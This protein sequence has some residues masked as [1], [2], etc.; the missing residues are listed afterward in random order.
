[1]SLIIDWVTKIIL[2]L[3]IAAIV[4][5][6]LP[7]DNMKKYAKL[8][9]G[10]ILILIMM[11][12]LFDLFQADIEQTVRASI[13]KLENVQ[14]KD[15]SIEKE[16]ELQKI[17]IQNGQHAYILEQMAVQLENLAKEPLRE[18]FQAEIISMDFVFLR[19]GEASYENLEEVIVLLGDGDGE[20]GA[21][22]TVEDVVINEPEEKEKKDLS[23]MEELLIEVWELTDKKL[24]LQ[25]EGGET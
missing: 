21:V 10:L 4:D 2:F 11:Q 6:M 24:S 22:K 8:T 18:E 14:E 23:G 1:M 3:I 20:K 25:W 5:M 17:E 13:D 16:I 7:S 19:E 9:V 15:F 12:P